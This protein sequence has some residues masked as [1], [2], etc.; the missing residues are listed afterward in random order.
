M[1]QAA[2]MRAIT[3]GLLLLIPAIGLAGQAPSPFYSD[4]KGE[5]FLAKKWEEL[6]DQE[7]Q[8]VRQA[9]ERYQ[10]LPQDRQEQLRRK[11]EKMP[12]QEKEKYRLE[13]KRRD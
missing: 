11:W 2:D 12:E 13:R 6:S 1:W 10:Q 9:K 5:F 7:K 3:L 8:R 4:G